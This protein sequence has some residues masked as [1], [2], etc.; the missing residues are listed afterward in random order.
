MG[1]MYVI[2]SNA[3]LG[4]AYSQILQ[5]YEKRNMKTGSL[6][7]IIY[8]NKWNIVITDE[9]QTGMAFNFTADHAV[10]GP[11]DDMEQFINLQPYIGRRMNDFIEHLLS[12]SDIQMRSLCLAALNALSRPLIGDTTQT[13]TFAVALIPESLDFIL[14]DDV[15]TVVGYGGPVA[16]IIGKCRELHVMDIRPKH[17]LYNLTVG[18]TIEYG[19]EGIIFHPAKENENILAGSDIVLLTGS[20]LVNGTYQELISYS[21]KARVIGMFGPSAGMIP[22]FLLNR[23]INYISSSKVSAGPQ[24]E[25]CLSNAFDLTSTFKECMRPYLVCNF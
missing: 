11:V 18:E 25:Y 12:K 16:R 17:R 1:G 2:A 22:A 23:G 5:E 19:P 8:R 13:G 4:M 15:V 14:A 7:K 21:R 9:Q 20:T 3:D 24:L 10:Y 6:R